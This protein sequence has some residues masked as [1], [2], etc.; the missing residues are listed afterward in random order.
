MLQVG[1]DAVGKRKWCLDG[2][3]GGRVEVM[4]SD[5]H[6]AGATGGVAVHRLNLLTR[7][8]APSRRGR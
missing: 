4:L 5:G 7:L 3:S 1:H 8:S 6:G 2:A